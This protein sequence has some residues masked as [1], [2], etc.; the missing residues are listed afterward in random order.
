VNEEYF[1]VLIEYFFQT[2]PFHVFNDSQD[3]WRPS[4]YPVSYSCIPHTDICE[5]KSYSHMN[6]C[7]HSGT[8]KDS[9]IFYHNWT[10]SILQQL[11]R[12]QI[13]RNCEAF[14]VR[15]WLHKKEISGQKRARYVFRVRQLLRTAFPTSLEERILCVFICNWI[16]KGREPRAN[17]VTLKL[18]RVRKA[19][20]PL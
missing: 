12:P 13:S 11:K 8:T 10:N 9:G 2:F 5:Q 6:L 19:D 1:F 16:K 3:W 15:G 4:P 20:K 14:V 18:W 7:Y 17:N